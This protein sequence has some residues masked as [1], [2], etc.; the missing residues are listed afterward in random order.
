MHKIY[1]NSIYVICYPWPSVNMFHPLVTKGLTFYKPSKLW[2]E[3]WA[4]R[5][6]SQATDG[7]EAIED[8]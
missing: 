6:S 7:V 4:D 2:E 8:E 3:V 5:T 1:T